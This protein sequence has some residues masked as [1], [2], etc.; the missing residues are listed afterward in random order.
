MTTDQQDE[1]R[2]VEPTDAERAALL[3][4]FEAY[5][6][7]KRLGWNDA[8]YCPKDGSMFLVIEPGSTG[9]H[10][11]KYEGSWP[12]G[13]WWVYDGDAWPSRPCLWK[14][15]AREDR[16]QEQPDQETRG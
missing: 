10:L 16:P 12:D 3:K 1:A 11:A 8:I 2:G 13:H 4:M 14:P 5:Q 7:L 15:R 9:V 6:E